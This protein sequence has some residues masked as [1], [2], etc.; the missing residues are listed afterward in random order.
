MNLDLEEKLS[1]PVTTTGT[2]AK[3]T[4]GQLLAQWGAPASKD[5]DPKNPPH[6][7]SVDVMGEVHFWVRRGPVAASNTTYERYEEGE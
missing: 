4:L 5:I 7:I 2:R 1:Q 3:A 6:F